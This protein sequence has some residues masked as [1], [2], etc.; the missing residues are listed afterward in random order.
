M[1]NNLAKFLAVGSLVVGGTLLSHLPANAAAITLQDGDGFSLILGGVN[2]TPFIGNPDIISGADFLDAFF[3]PGPSV[4][5]NPATIAV[6]P[7]N[8]IGGVT[9]F[10]SGPT[11]AAYIKDVNLLGGD[12]VV[13]T[14]GGPDLDFSDGEITNTFVTVGGAFNPFVTLDAIP[15]DS[16]TPDLAINLLS[17]SST[18][19]SKLSDGFARDA[20]SVLGEIEFVTFAPDGSILTRLGTGSFEGTIFSEDGTGSS[21]SLSFEVNDVNIPESSPVSALIGFGL[22]GSAFALKRKIR[23]G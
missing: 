11:T 21:G 16:F 6:A 5:G 8:V 15:S 9:D 3:G 19:T 4:G 7:G 2:Y 10:F 20:I 1:K 12:F 23:I 17:F 14:P 18:Q 22:V 13:T